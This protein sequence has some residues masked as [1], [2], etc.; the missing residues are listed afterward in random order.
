MKSKIF[1]NKFLYLFV[2]CF[3]AIVL[4]FVSFLYF[5]FSV[6]VNTLSL[7]SFNQEEFLELQNGLSR[8]YEKYGVSQD[9]EEIVVSKDN[10]LEENG[11][12]YISSSLLNSQKEISAFSINEKEE[13]LVS[14]S[15]L[16]DEYDI[17]ENDESYTLSTSDFTNRIIVSYDGELE[18]YNTE[19]YAEGLGYHIYQYET[20]E[21]TL[22]AYNYYLNLPYVESVSY[23]NVV[24]AESVD[25][26]IT[27]ESQSDFHSWGAEVIGVD[28]YM[29]YLNFLYT[30]EELETVYV[31][32]LDS[33]VNTDHVLLRNRVDFD[34]SADFTTGVMVTGKEAVEDDNGHGSH[35]AGIIADQTKDNVKIISLKVLKANGKGSVSNILLAI[36]Y[37]LSLNEATEEGDGLNIRVMNMSL[38][39]ED[40][41]GY[42]IHNRDLENLVTSVYKNNNIMSVVSA[43]N[44]HNDTISNIPANVEEAIVVA[45]LDP[46]MTIASYSN[47]GN[48]V[49]FCAPGTSVESSYINKLLIN[50]STFYRE[51][52]GTSMAAPH[53]TAAFAL[54]LS[55]PKYS[56]YS[57]A[58]LISIL[59]QNAIDLGDENWDRVYGYGCVNI[60]KL[61]INTSGEVEFSETELNHTE[62]F[63]VTLSYNVDKPYTIYY[64]LDESMPGIN[65]QVYSGPITISKTTQIRA[66]AYV[67][68]DE[69]D[70]T[71]M[72]SEISTITYYLNNIDLDSSFVVEGNGLFGTLVSY[73]GNLTTLNIQDVI[74]NV[75]I[76]SIGE[77][78]FSNSN[79]ENIILPNSCTTIEDYAFY[80]A[81]NLK[82]VSANYVRYIGDYSFANCWGLTE[83]TFPYIQEVGNGA[84][85]SL[86]LEK[87]SLG[88]N[89]TSFGEMYDFHV[90]NL[91]CYTGS[92]IDTTL[93]QYTNNLI[94]INLKTT[95]PSNASRI[96]SKTGSNFSIDFEVYG[97]Y[98]YIYSSSL[99]DDS[100]NEYN[101]YVTLYEDTTDFEDNYTNT[102]TY[103]FN[104][105]GVG[106][107]TFGFTAIDIFGNMTEEISL[108]VLVL[109]ASTEIYYLVLEG[110]NYNVY[111]D[112]QL[113]QDGFILYKGISDYEVTLEAE[114]SYTLS[115][116]EVVM[117]DVPIDELNDINQNIVTFTLPTID[118][119]V[120]I[121]CVVSEIQEFY[122]TF[123]H[124][125]NIDIL[126]SDEVIDS[127]LNVQR[128]QNL[129]FTVVPKTG[130][131]IDKVLMNGQ[132]ISL[133][134]TNSFTL[135]YILQDMT[136]EV[137]ESILTF[138]IN[139]AYGYGGVTS[140]NNFDTANYGENKV[141]NILPDD[142]YEIESIVVN[143]QEIEISD[144]TLELQNIT[145]DMSVVI[146][147]KPIQTGLSESELTI[148]I[149][150]A[151]ILG[152]GLIWAC[153]EII[154]KINKN[155]KYKYK[156]NYSK[157][158]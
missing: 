24:T 111:I 1:N 93:S 16:E 59:Q 135:S 115:N 20:K 65:S 118:G 114:S 89:L 15:S 144:N 128:E 116:Y 17:V 142:G 34:L 152:I 126:V 32:V 40:E 43:G 10:V 122:L 148:V 92:D 151:T 31:A 131:K 48:T 47:Y 49:D 156:K 87:L 108:T 21:D 130:Y 36:N 58:D 62:E 63:K 134:Q 133:N 117:R 27:V 95:L 96:I 60:S 13:N 30:D 42:E 85:N 68:A 75:R 66:V 83:L 53:V 28:D 147:F 121:N 104:N 22:D 74:N 9:G 127:V 25:E 51:L 81:F 84:F 44:L 23:D 4:C 7:S 129:T 46:T 82:S 138:N 158:F 132:R 64:T 154:L 33:G 101:N 2:A 18:A 56:D 73:S 26:E 139:I 50:D 106:N 19:Y 3:M 155:K 78:A 140:S 107:Y 150:F 70:E 29:A 67:V 77:N 11:D 149:L 76:T 110:N 123:S 119:N 61:G 6:N 37:I 157:H 35:T 153:V 91:E 143:G 38:G 103:T 57:N 39:L 45:A 102:L 88:S 71:V 99:S 97:K 125:D 54:L 137:Y 90:Q 79:V 52:S 12:E 113:A 105:L 72:K 136:I 112:G 100:G 5:D 120:N 141:Y 109:P 98:P 94:S 146:T 80:Y 124:S 14:L 69:N 41:N 8:I 145:S 55:S 86:R